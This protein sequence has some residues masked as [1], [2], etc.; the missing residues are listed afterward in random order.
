[1]TARFFI[2]AAP[3][4]ISAKPP[5]AQRKSAKRPSSDPETNIGMTAV[6]MMIVLG[7]GPCSLSPPD[8]FHENRSWNSILSCLFSLHKAMMIVRNCILTFSC[9]LLWTGFLQAQRPFYRPQVHEFGIQLF[10]SHYFLQ[11]LS[12]AAIRDDPAFQ[13]YSLNPVN[14]LRYKF[15]FNPSDAVRA[16]LFYRTAT[17]NLENGIREFSAYEAKRTDIDIKI[18]YE[19][20][21]HLRKFQLFAGADAILNL[22]KS[23]ETATYRSNILPPPPS[24]TRKESYSSTRYGGG[25][26]LGMRYFVS[27]NLSFALENEF[28][29]TRSAK[30][31]SGDASDLRMFTDTA[32][33]LNLLSLY[34]SFHFKRMKKSCTC[35]K[36]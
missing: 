6:R 3:I 21:F 33:G 4:T 36:P 18:G 27:E 17:Y 35:G 13:S 25:L 15:G 8:S 29:Y 28:Y 16:G 20:R 14:G 12:D 34:V 7:F 10:S 26:F 19:R 30:S 11:E 24:E 2:S 9:L 22:G 23:D 1:M 31:S 32:S 5:S